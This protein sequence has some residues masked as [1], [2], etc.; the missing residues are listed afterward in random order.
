MLPFAD[1]DIEVSSGECFDWYDQ[2][3]KMN[4]VWWQQLTGGNRYFVKQQKKCANLMRFASFVRPLAAAA[5]WAGCSAWFCFPVSVSN[6]GSSADEVWLLSNCVSSSMQL[7]AV[8]QTLWS[9]T[10]LIDIT[11]QWQHDWKSAS[12]VIFFLVQPH[13]RATS[14]WSATMSMGVIFMAALCSRCAH[15]IFAL[16]F[17]LLLLSF[18]F[19]YSPN[20]SGCRLD[21]CHTYTHDVALV[22]I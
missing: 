13:N 17:L 20:I 10:Y 12:V 19:I 2:W 9:D 7:S 15:Y 18:F 4:T 8:M 6:P 16:W 5:Q 1:S 11:S 22:R 3:R 21:V 14:I